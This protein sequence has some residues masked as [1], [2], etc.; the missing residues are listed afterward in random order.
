MIRASTGVVSN[1]KQSFLQLKSNTS[2]LILQKLREAAQVPI[3]RMYYVNFNENITAPYGVVLNNWPLKKFA[4]PGDI[5]SMVEVKIVYN[6]FRT[7]ATKF[8]KLTAAE[9]EDWDETRFNNAM[10]SGSEDAT[11][12][13]RNAP[14]ADESS[15]NGACWILKS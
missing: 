8:H 3:S 6:A 1:Y 11:N 9:W 14:V 12:E 15:I 7:G 2:A 13:D 4:S 5:G 10:G